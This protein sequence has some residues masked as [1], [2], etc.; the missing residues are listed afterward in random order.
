MGT[1]TANQIAVCMPG[2]D[3]DI[4]NSVAPDISDL[5][6]GMSDAILGM[7]DFDTTNL[8]NDLSDSWTALDQHISKTYVSATLDWSSNYNKNILIKLA[9]PTNYATYDGCNLNDFD[10]DSWHP[11]IEGG[12]DINCYV[13]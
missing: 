12:A 6:N 9:D 4:I 1:D 2:E 13:S 5:I 8:L 7:D 10:K 3:G 11:S